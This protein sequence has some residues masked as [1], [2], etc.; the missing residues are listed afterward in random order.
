MVTVHA[1]AKDRPLAQYHHP[2]SMLLRS[3]N[4]DDG[5]DN[6]NNNNNSYDDN[7][8]RGSG[9]YLSRRLANGHP[10][11]FQQQLSQQNSLGFDTSVLEN[12]QYAFGGGGGSSSSNNNNNNNNNSASR[13]ETVKQQ[14]ISTQKSTRPARPGQTAD[15]VVFAGPPSSEGQNKKRRRY[16]SPSEIA[17][18]DPPNESHVIDRV[19][20]GKERRRTQMRMAQRAY[21]QRKQNELL[22]THKRL[23]EIGDAVTDL[24]TVYN[25]LSSKLTTSGFLP[26][27]PDLA[28]KLEE[29]TGK[30]Q[31]L[32]QL[33]SLPEN[34]SD[35]K[36][37]TSPPPPPA[38]QAL[39]M[40]T[41]SSQDNLG[42]L[43]PPS[44]CAG[45]SSPCQEPGFVVPKVEEDTTASAFTMPS[46]NLLFYPQ[47]MPPYGPQVTL[48]TNT[49]GV[50]VPNNSIPQLPAP[51]YLSP[52]TSYSY[53]ETSF[54]RRLQRKCV[55]SAYRVLISDRV[56][57]ARK[58]RIFKLAFRVWN[59]K[60]LVEKFRQSALGW[61]FD[62][63]ATPY[64]SVG[65]AGTHYP[66]TWNQLVRPVTN[67]P[68]PTHMAHIQHPGPDKSVEAIVHALGMDDGDWFD[69]LDIE[70][71]LRGMGVYL[72]AHT[73]Y[74]E[75]MQGNVP[76]VLN[77]D[78]FL[79]R[80]Y[81]FFLA[82]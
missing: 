8:L 2:L 13:S 36:S 3:A 34:H 11:D 30:F 7:G 47:A 22:T 42:M 35:Q 33:S 31:A 77:V 18:T 65:G 52:P 54:A 16:S 80:K 62:D 74:A 10:V 44:S 55:E 25:S 72:E 40:S 63:P 60:Q 17:S 9:L 32:A 43:L 81:F 50:P 23:S 5:D 1:C 73:T 76:A 24:G 71:H 79:D 69:C 70:G 14:G 27:W 56:H 15:T 48:A 59:K 57:P 45:S 78:Q 19:P 53:Q 68:W 51:T 37:S 4:A 20:P 61:E 67:G 12:H 21:R 41:S 58:A 82:L 29:T 66:R 6:D 28:Q 49:S 75:F 64:F 38:A 26:L 46:S 39:S